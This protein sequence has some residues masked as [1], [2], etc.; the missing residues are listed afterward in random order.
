MRTESITSPIETGLEVAVIGMAGRFPLARNLEEFWLNLRDGIECISYFSVEEAI[1]SGVEPSKA[2]H[3]DYVKAKGLLE[4]VEYF[5]ANFFDY[6]A[7]EAKIMEPQ[8]RIFQECAWEVLE[9][10]GYNPEVYR[11]KIGVYGGSSPNYYWQGLCTFSGSTAAL[12]AFSLT[13]LTG[14]D[15]LTTRVSHSFNL[16]GP[17]LVVQT[18]CSTSLVAIH[19]ASQALL[20]GECT[21]ALAGGVCVTLPLKK[22]GEYRKGLVLSPDGHCRAFDAEADGFTHGNG[23]GMVALKLLEDALADGD[24]IHAVIKGSAVNNDGNRKAGFSAPSIK[25]QVE[26]I[27]SALSTAEVEPESISY[28]E[29]HG[30]GTPLGDPIEIEALTRAFNTDKKRFCKLGSVKTNIGHL[31]A[32]AGIAGILKMIL[33]MKHRQLP[34]SLH[35]MTPNP[36]IDFVNSPFSINTELTP[37]ENGKYP[38]RAG[39]SSF[40]IGGTNAHIIL[41]EA[42]EPERVPGKRQWK[43]L[44]FSA[45]TSTALERQCEN[46]LGYLKKNPDTPLSEEAFTLQVG[47][48]GFKHRRILVCADANEAVAALSDYSTLPR[49]SVSG[50]K[51]RVVFMFSGIGSQ[52]VNMG[53]DLYLHEPLFREEMERCFKLLKPLTGFDLKEILYP[54]STASGTPAGDKTL[55]EVQ[56]KLQQIEIAQLAVFTLEYALARVLMNWGV[57]PHAIIGYS[58]GEYIAAC[59][60]GVFSLEEALRIVVNR[61]KLL[62][63]SPRGAMWSIPLSREE[64]LP[65]LSQGLDIA[66]DNGS[67]CIVAG[68]ISAISAFAEKMKDKKIM[69]MPVPNT[70]AIHSGMMEPLLPEFKEMLKSVTFTSPKIP[71]ISSLT[72]KWA[73]TNE[74]VTPDYWIAHLRNTVNFADGIALLSRKPD[75]IFIEIGPGRDLVTMVKRYLDDKKGQK[76]VNMTRPYQKKVSDHLYVLNKLG[77]LWLYGVNIDWLAFNSHEKLRRLPLPTYPFEKKRYWIETTLVKIFSDLARGIKPVDSPEN[78]ADLVNDAKPDV[79]NIVYTPTAGGLDEL[80]RS[81]LSTPYVP[82]KRGLEKVLVDIWQRFFGTGPIGICDDFFELGGDSLKATNIS[83]IIRKELNM[84]VPV[85][86]FFNCQ[87]IE[88]IVR[89]LTEVGPETEH[90]SLEIAEQREYYPVSS[91]QRRLYVLQQLAPDNISYNEPS[92][93]VL[94]GRLGKEQLEHIFRQLI[95]KHESLRTSFDLIQGETVQKIHEPGDIDFTV[96]YVDLPEI[97]ANRQNRQPVESDSA[98]ITEQILNRFIKPFNLKIAPLF[99]VGLI[100]QDFHQFVL[101]VDIHHT[102]TDG[103]SHSIIMEDFITLYNGGTISPL[104]FQYKEFSR[105]QNHLFHSGKMLKQEEF[106]LK[107]FAEE[108]SEI[109]LPTDYPRPTMLT[110]EG[111]RIT[112]RMAGDELKALRKMASENDSTLFMVLLA[113]F[114]IF[115]SKLS[116]Q[117][118]IACGTLIA[119]RKLSEFQHIAGMFVNTLAI[120]NYPFP[121]MTFT[122]FLKT[123]RKKTLEVY[124]NQDYQFETLVEKVVKNRDTGRNPLFDFIFVL[125]NMQGPRG[126]LSELKIKPYG[127]KNTTSKFDMKLEAEEANEYLFMTFE[128]RVKLFKEETIRRFIGYFRKLIALALENPSLKIKDMQLITPREKEELLI[129][130]NN[131]SSPYPAGK[132]LSQLFLRQAEQTPDH[133][134]LIRRLPDSGSQI[135]MREVGNGENVS[136]TYKELAEK[137]VRLA[138]Y[139][140][141]KGTGIDSIVGIK[142]NRSPE[143]VISILGIMTAHAAYLPMDPEYPADRIHFM[144]A[145]SNAHILLTEKEVADYFSREANTMPPEMLSVHW[146]RSLEPVHSL[147]YIIYTSGST[148]R[149]KGVMVEQRNIVNYVCWAI[150]M[151]VREEAV[152]FP[153]FTSLSFDLTITSIFTP[154]LSGNAIVV[155][156]GDSKEPLIEKVILDNRV[157]VVKLTPSHLKLLEKLGTETLESKVKRFILGGEAL[158][159]QLAGKMVEKFNHDIIIYNEYG[160]TETSVGCMIYQFSPGA[161]TRQSVPIGRP[162]GN[163]RIYILDKTRHP[164]PLSVPGE[165]YISGEGVARGYMNRPQLTSERF[166]NNPFCADNRAKRMYKTGDL[167]RFIPGNNIEFL[168][169]IDQQVKIRGFRVEIEEIQGK[170]LEFRKNKP[171]ILSEN[172]L[173]EIHTRDQKRCQVCLLPG[174]YPGIHLDEEGVCNICREFQR[175]KQDVENYFKSEEDF[176]Q[177][178]TET[179]KNRQSEYDC[180]LLFSGGKDSTY[181][182]YRLIDMG[183]RV[184]TFTFDNGYISAAAFNNIERTT[185]ALNVKNIVCT[186]K[187]M[188]KVF[189]E[190]LNAFHDVCHGCWNTL[191]VYGARVAYE[192]GINLVISGLS[193]GQIFEMRLEELFRQGIFREE[194]VEQHLH[195]FRKS[196]LSKNNIF[197]RLLDVDLPGEAVDKIQFTDFF[198]YFPA[199][200]AEIREYLLGKGWVQPEDTG[201]CSSNCLINDVGIYVHLQTEG[202]HFY[203]PQLSWDCRLGCLPREQGLKEVTFAVDGKNLSTQRILNEI[204]YYRPPIKDAVV[205]EREGGNGDKKLAAYIV[206]DELLAVPAIRDY[207]ARQLPDYMIPSEFIQLDAIPL[208]S[209][210]KVDRKL[211][212]SLGKKIEMGVEYAAPTSN[213]E[214][215]LAELWKEILNL[216]DIGIYDNFFDL[217]G[218]SVDIIR[219]NGRIRE[220][221]EVDMPIIA[222]Y[223]YTTVAGLSQ[224]LDTG[225]AVEEST[226]KDRREIMERGKT[227][228]AK[229]R[230]KRQLRE[231]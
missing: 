182:L 48:K 179:Q 195:L 189:V 35:F 92:V 130:F 56:G 164:L 62:T 12:N 217:G 91:A 83:S 101:I 194:E 190:S 38:L 127:Y 21:L 10:A 36:K 151:Y 59:T 108:I 166:I 178:L 19:L 113:M 100:K 81:E 79:G 103:T 214:K 96:E 72:G 162:A 9:N 191:N 68:E 173:K 111:N 165:I 139:L 207:L 95:K 7:L 129:R 142:M 140:E 80:L 88:A 187:N 160:P 76:I 40:G 196:F 69:G 154:L 210:G 112:D 221:F 203:A 230:E 45:R 93:F 70:M 44:T 53:L 75:S 123:V 200:V 39:I 51:T 125:Q 2:Q 31:D 176:L 8:L 63:R 186:T 152:N 219:V 167:A 18:A 141:E 47:R 30:T 157:G 99:R 136:L 55:A 177:L 27:K 184:L 135:V 223:Q 86:E 106:W 110:F 170:L 198:R 150:N 201:F 144:L 148:G 218:T 34:P 15:Y 32:A 73:G 159:T 206:S 229:R 33:A 43:I 175:N 61:G 212:Q 205:M 4:D 193:R 64:V 138:C 22:G 119:G 46:F 153:L 58:F 5:D 13:Q 1:A 109:N 54:S 11:G 220:V 211:L 181:V 122:H 224:Y 163:A 94:E 25:A 174:H 134:A 105:W 183:L 6:T 156:E 202:Y 74:I 197:T 42:I 117:E 226:G 192:Y 133:T 131:T 208:T 67:S 115:L 26:L 120:R 213:N 16:T 50:D 29:T 227:D 155:Y 85:I 89:Y 132:T 180:L 225:E 137:S 147:A 107:E 17:S 124:E 77:Y 228:R 102:I 23:V 41:E 161:E 215:K 171:V 199:T 204:G 216:K 90:S 104:P 185:S 209:N 145:D 66:I 20:S 28:I 114:N 188:N 57:K 97:M 24:Y 231:R 37:W 82:P 116:G 98:K 60:A 126:H 71:Y 78:T 52:Y 128:Y 172:D 169:R 149:P 49:Y 65:L 143:A 121:E 168:G 84:E 87:N 222:M 14:R 3:P 146:R 118:D 158:E